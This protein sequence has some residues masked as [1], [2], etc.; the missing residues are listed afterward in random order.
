MYNTFDLEVRKIGGQELE[1]ALNRYSNE[2]ETQEDEK[3][4]IEYVIGRFVEQKKNNFAAEDIKEEIENLVFGHIQRH[5]V[6]MDFL[7]VE[8]DEEGR[9]SFILTETGKNALK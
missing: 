6:E 1:E 8:I 7:D 9:P 5:L 2:E 3:L 4:L